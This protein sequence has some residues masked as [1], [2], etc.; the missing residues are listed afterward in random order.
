M[1]HN[2]LQWLILIHITSTSFN[3]VYEIILTL[4]DLSLTHLNAGAQKKTVL[5]PKNGKII[6]LQY[7][8]IKHYSAIP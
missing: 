6:F 8:P 7:N 4:N 2:F 3:L 1:L 5:G